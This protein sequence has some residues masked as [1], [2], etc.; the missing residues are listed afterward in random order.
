[1]TIEKFQNIVSACRYE[2]IKNAPD[3]VNNIVI[4]LNQKTYHK[5]LGL[6]NDKEY[7]YYPAIGKKQFNY[8]GVCVSWSPVLNDNEDGFIFGILH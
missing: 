1:M 7:W 4:S 3:K 2:T 8:M 6:L 5:I